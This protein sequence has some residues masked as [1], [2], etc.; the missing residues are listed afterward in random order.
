MQHNNE[1]CSIYLVQLALPLALAPA[2]TV[3]SLSPLLS[4][5]PSLVSSLSLYLSLFLFG[6]GL[7][8]VKLAVR[9]SQCE[10]ADGLSIG[11]LTGR[12]NG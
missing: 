8:A 5:Y 9:M 1:I 7:K 12:V 4:L 2:F 3:L 6:Q 10:L 11:A